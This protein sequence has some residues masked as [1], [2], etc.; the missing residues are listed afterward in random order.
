[1]AIAIDDSVGIFETVCAGTLLAIL[2]S[3]VMMN[4]AMMDVDRVF[5]GKKPG[6]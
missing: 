4:T 1:M 5:E 6:I 2:Q 3:D